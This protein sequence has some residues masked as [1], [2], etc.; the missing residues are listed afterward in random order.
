LL[1]RFRQKKFIFD[2]VDIDDA[3]VRVG[4]LLE[5]SFKCRKERKEA[6]FVKAFVQSCCQVLASHAKEWYDLIESKGSIFIICFLGYIG[7]FVV[8]DDHRSG[9]IVVELIGRINKCGV[10]SPRFDVAVSVMKAL[11]M[12]QII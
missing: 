12:Y 3:Y 5:N 2:A 7:E 6:S 9:K 11:K 8:L 1:S 4:R 10:I